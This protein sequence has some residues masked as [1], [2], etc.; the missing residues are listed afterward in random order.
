MVF[1][2]SAVKIFSFVIVLKIN[3]C[4]LPVY[5]AC[6]GIKDQTRHFEFIRAKFFGDFPSKREVNLLAKCLN[7]IKLALYLEEKVISREVLQA[8]LVQVAGTKPC[9]PLKADRSCRP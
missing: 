3:R 6:C 5:L 1:H 7:F 4:I 2:F 8:A 9:H